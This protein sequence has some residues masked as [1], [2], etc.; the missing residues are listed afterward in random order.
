[1]SGDIEIPPTYYFSG[2]TFNPSF[3]QSSTSD[4][5]TLSTA[6]SK[7]LTYPTAQGTETISNLL[8]TSIETSTPTTAF[9]LLSTQTG[10]VNIANTTT[11]TAG[12]TIKIGASTLTSVHCGSIDH[13]G[14]T[15]NNS[16]AP[17]LGDI[18]ICDLQTSGN[19]NLGT[20]T[21][22]T[23]GNGGAIN[24]G[25]GLN[26]ANPIN[27][28]SV[29]AVVSS[30]PIN[31]NTST[32]ASGAV[33]IGSA[34]STTNVKGNFTATGLITADGGLTLNSGDL[35]TASGGI[36]SLD[37]DVSPVGSDFQ[38]AKS[39]TNGAI[40]IGHN[41]TSGALNIGCGTGT[42][43]IAGGDINI[44]T[45]GSGTSVGNVNIGYTATTTTV[46][47]KFTSTGLLTANGGITLASGQLL[48][49]T[50]LGI[51]SGQT[52]IN[53]AAANFTIPSNINRD[54]YLFCNTNATSY[55]ITLPARLNNQIIRFRNFSGQTLTITAP[56]TTPA[57]SIYPT[58]FTTNFITT[59]TGFLNNTVQTLYCDGTNWLGF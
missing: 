33:N 43:R 4:Y 55:T 37:Y 49:A 50:G 3:Y 36:K 6:K 47:S 2:I 59:W 41:Q 22:I 42:S 13:K 5:L 45:N 32:A 29:N 38:I 25:G 27:I 54:Y 18:S 28:G 44:G 31:L 16:V 11:G 14:T 23:T 19:L 7:F 46:N 15:I 51:L 56:T 8:T 57:T 34:S 48:T 9:N 17:A 24:I 52:A 39:Q 21:R 10:N 12:Q 40:Y 1:M 20:G 58:D 35:L 26:A 53:V 30:S